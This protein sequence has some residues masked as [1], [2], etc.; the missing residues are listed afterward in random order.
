M[1]PKVKKKNFYQIQSNVSLCI[2][3]IRNS[4]QKWRRK[5]NLNKIVL[6]SWRQPTAIRTELDTVHRAIVTLHT[7]THI[8]H[9]RQHTHCT[10]M[11]IHTRLHT[12][13]THS[14]TAI[15]TELDTVHR[16][17]VTLH[18]YTHTVHTR[19]HTHCTQ[20]PSLIPRYNRLLNRLYIL[21]GC[22]FTRYNRLS[23][24]VVQPDWQP[25][26]QQVASCKRG[27]T[28]TATVTLHV[29]THDYAHIVHTVV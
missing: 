18:M 4:W 14:P 11:T 17:I 27:L 1:E 6:T 22:L 2:R 10:H 26:W 9:T 12:H 8:V 5:A 24:R 13:C 3:V 25:V 20:S 29:Y 16:A 21:V 19:Q 7:Y 15:R 23:N 28:V